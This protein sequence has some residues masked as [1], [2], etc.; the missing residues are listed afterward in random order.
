MMIGLGTLFSMLKK[1]L[2]RPLENTGALP[3]RYYLHEVLKSLDHDNIGEA[4]KLLRMSRGALIDK[5]RWE[6][7]R[8]QI[9]FRCR[10]L[11][12][13]HRK[14][15]NFLEEKIKEQK[16]HGKLPWR[17]FRKEPVENL[18]QYEK[19][20]ALERQAQDLLEK[21]ESELKDILSS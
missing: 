2:G 1:L 17:W 3:T 20:L 12:E 4:V 14:R 5:S 9:I 16:K 10:I 21:Y 15:I 11:R 8:Q 19:T 7:V 18:V 13:R 6:M